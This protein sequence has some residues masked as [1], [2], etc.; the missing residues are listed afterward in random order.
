[1]AEKLVLAGKMPRGT[2][3]VRKREGGEFALTINDS[4]E[5]SLEVGRPKIKKA[6]GFTLQIQVKHYKIRPLDNSSG[7]FITTRKVFSSVKDLISYYMSMLF[8]Y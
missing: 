1:M 5:N 4:K 8:F 2:F 3:L 6:L 7:F